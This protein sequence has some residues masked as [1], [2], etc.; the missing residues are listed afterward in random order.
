MTT[1][2]LSRSVLQSSIER[3]VAALYA[4]QDPRGVWIG[5]VGR[6]TIPCIMYLLAQA[7][8][9]RSDRPQTRKALE[10]LYANQNDDGGWGQWKGDVSRLDYAKLA[11]Q[12]IRRNRGDEA[13]AVCAD[14][15][16]REKGQS[17][18]S[19]GS[20]LENILALTMLATVGESGWKSVPLPPL[21]LAILGLERGML[22]GPLPYAGTAAVMMKTERGG[23]KPWD[24]LLLGRG[25]KWLLEHL[26]EDGSWMGSV[27][28]TA[29][30]LL[31]MKGHPKAASQIEK[32]FAY[33]DSVQCPDG[34]FGMVKTLTTWETDLAAL[35]LVQAGESPDHPLVRQT[36]SWL[37]SIQLPDGSWAW[38]FHPGT[39]LYGDID[40]TIYACM[41]LRKVKPSSPAIERGIAW[42]KSLQGQEGGWATF[43]KVMA[44]PD[45][46]HAIPDLTG[47]AV[48][49]LSFL[50]GP[51][52][53]A[54]Q[55]GC[56]WL[57][58]NQREDGSW[59]GY[60]G[61]RFVYG[62]S[63]AVVGLVAARSESIAIER[64]ADYLERRQNEDGGWGE[65]WAGDSAVSAAEQTSWALVGL[66]A[67]GRSFDS[68][69]VQRGIRWLLDHQND[70]GSWPFSMAGSF[71]HH[72][73][74]S[75]GTTVLPQPVA[76]MALS[77]W[78][79]RLTG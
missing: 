28:T 74:G 35:A 60:W 20:G 22:P 30:I 75:Y 55:A 63:C 43:S 42:V 33:C 39:I 79:D 1:E 24:G 45:M 62:T 57:I 49:A 7:E 64:G 10:W 11:R 25:E 19:G 26:A 65:N 73:M 50:E 40:D 34:G 29:M 58:A 69:C 53:D 72:Y 13:V 32:A 37:E 71:T 8:Y 77:A 67:A 66:A 41:F 23:K 9:G 27:H 6:T 17:A 36:A 21:P 78:R 51:S 31:A 68:A 44:R 59:R 18:V 47:H 5:E 48:E 3:G 56:R 38:D 52:I 15:F 2:T 16:V 76:I 12:A 14:E 61:T 70:D 54:V 46:A 4:L